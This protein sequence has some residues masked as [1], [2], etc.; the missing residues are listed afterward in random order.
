VTDAYD[1]LNIGTRK[2]LTGRVSGVDDNNA[3]DINSCLF[4]VFYLLLNIVS[5]KGPVLLLI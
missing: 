1:L 3:P 4:G 5:V 2:D